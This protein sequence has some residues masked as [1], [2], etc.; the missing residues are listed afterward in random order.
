MLNM[1]TSLM[2]RIVSAIILAPCFIMAIKF[3]GMVLAILLFIAFLISL[4]EWFYLSKKLEYFVPTMLLGF[5][6]MSISF[7]SF[8]ALREVYSINVLIIFIGMIWVS[9]IGAYFVGKTFGGPKLIKEVSPNKTWS[10]FGG[11]L[12][13][14][15]LFCVLW[16]WLFGFHDVFDHN[17]WY[18]LFPITAALGVAIGCVGQAGD[19]MISFVKRQADVKDTGTLI[20]GH[21]G[22]LDRID[23]MLLGAP[24]YLILITLLSYVF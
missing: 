6:Y 1:S 9:D 22:L 10:G 13:F 23:S 19:L 18:A 15:A 14:P 21:G 16:V 7:A 4:S 17:S 24:V 2:K 5:I 20:P 8:L 11:A 3:G 12:F